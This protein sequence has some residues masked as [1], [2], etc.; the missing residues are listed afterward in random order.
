MLQILLRTTVAIFN[1]KIQ[2]PT[3]TKSKFNGYPNLQFHNKNKL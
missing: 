3:D 1:F 2:I